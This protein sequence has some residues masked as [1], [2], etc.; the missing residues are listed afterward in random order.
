MADNNAEQRPSTEDTD[1]PRTNTDQERGVDSPNV[2]E[3]RGGDQG[4]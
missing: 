3:E 4:V 2:D 1:T